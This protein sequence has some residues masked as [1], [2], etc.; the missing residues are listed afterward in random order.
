[1]WGT[2][3]LTESPEGVHQKNLNEKENIKA[4]NLNALHWIE[5][6]IIDMIFLRSNNIVLKITRLTVG[7]SVTH[8]YNL[9]E[10]KIR[11]F[12]NTRLT[13]S[14]AVVH[15]YDLLEE[16]GGRPV[17]DGV[18]SPQQGGPRLVVEANYDRSLG[19]QL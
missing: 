16:V 19:Q 11:K 4:N 9:F 17:Q 5:H 13:V 15:Q 8:K 3:R 10:K 7:W 1:M 14:R 2:A 18:Y 6:L 12:S